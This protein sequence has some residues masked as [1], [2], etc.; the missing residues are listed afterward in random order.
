MQQGW[1]MLAPPPLPESPSSSSCSS[2]S[3]PS[4]L[5]GII[6]PPQDEEVINQPTKSYTLDE[7]P[8]ES[9]LR[10]KYFEYKFSVQAVHPQLRNVLLC[11][12]VANE[13]WFTDYRFICK[14]NT[15]TEMVSLTN[16]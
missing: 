7:A 1:L 15:E 16:S 3:F 4:L 8:N 13:L 14:L 2:S 5:D 9:L 11:P 12:E 10:S 6:E